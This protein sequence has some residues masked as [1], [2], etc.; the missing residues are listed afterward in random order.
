MQS[1]ERVFHAVLFEALAL[2]ILIPASA[3]ITGKGTSD[4]AIVG[5][6]LSLF[7]VIWNYYY[8][9]GFD[10]VFG[11]ERKERTLKQRICHTAGFEGGLIIITVPTIAWFLSISLME[12][13]LLEAGFLVFFFFYAT[14]FN[15][16]YD[17]FQPFKQWSKKA[18][19]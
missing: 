2:A 17:R 3:L 14:G 13:V 1:K 16:L 18:G 10:R 4:L 9:I 5:I 15:W 7:T 19:A 8:N 11:A 6:G 12:A